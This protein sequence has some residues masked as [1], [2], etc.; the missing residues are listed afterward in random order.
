VTKNFKG[1]YSAGI[2][3]IP[4]YVVKKCIEATKNPLTHICNAFI[5]LGIFLDRFKTTKVKSTA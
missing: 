1:K 3:Q 5:E 4:D 2:Y